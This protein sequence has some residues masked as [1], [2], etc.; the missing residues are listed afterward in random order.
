MIISDCQ[1]SGRL[2]ILYSWHFYSP[3]SNHKALVYIQVRYFTYNSDTYFLRYRVPYRTICRRLSPSLGSEG[4]IYIQP[5]CRT[6][7]WP[8][9][10]RLF[11]WNWVYTILSLVL[12]VLYCLDPHRDI[13]SAYSW[14]LAGNFSSVPQ[15][16]LVRHQWPSLLQDKLA[17]LKNTPR[18]ETNH[19]SIV[20]C[21]AIWEYAKT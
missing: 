11:G 13:Y 12:F 18:S 6:K 1:T 7:Q 8:G 2:Y 10:G 9:C 17:S 4:I 21:V 3:K 15:S 5:Q 19:D 16:S 20:K 14:E